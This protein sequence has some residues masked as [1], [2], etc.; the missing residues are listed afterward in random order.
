MVGM[1]EEHPGGKNRCR[2]EGGGDEAGKPAVGL[3]TRS[4][5][6]RSAMYFY[7]TPLLAAAR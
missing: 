1:F 2:G 6:I 3:G 7:R 4:D 5:A